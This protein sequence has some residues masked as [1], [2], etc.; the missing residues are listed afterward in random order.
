MRIVIALLMVVIGA[1]AT[2]DMKVKISPSVAYIYVYHKGKAIKIQRIQD[3]QHKL[4]GEYAKTYRPGQYIQ[5]I[6]LDNTIK[7]IGEIEVIDFMRN[8]VNRKKGLIIDVRNRTSFKKEAIPSAVNIPVGITD[9]REA[10]S[11]IFHSLGMKQKA[12][13]TWDSTNAM[14][15]LIYCGG[16]WCKKSQEF[17]K[18]IVGLGYPA[19][20]IKYYR[21]GFQMWK[22]LGLTTVKN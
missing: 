20:K 2:P 18:K 12:N 4:T 6:K 9:N 13:G 5:P 22:I 8:K 15:L 7:T 3:P 19:E 14:E 11:K 1:Y 21:G 16:L 17:I 10:M